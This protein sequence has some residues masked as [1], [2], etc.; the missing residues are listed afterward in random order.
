MVVGP[1]LRNR[2]HDGQRKLHAA[3]NEEFQRVVQHGGVRTSGI[4]H[5]KHLVELSF[6]M[7]GR[8][9][10]LTG[11]HFVGIS[12]DR[13]DLTVVNDKTVGMRPHP[14]WIRVGAEPGVNHGNG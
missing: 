10:L 4:Y 14:A 2:H 3:H 8:H 9:G 7:V 13:V 6:Q 12:A 1:G 5:R 11:Q